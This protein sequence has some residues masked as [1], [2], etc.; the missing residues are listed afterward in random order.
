MAEIRGASF[1][2]DFIELYNPTDAAIDLT[3]WSVEYFASNGSSGGKI[4]LSGTIAP[5]GYYLV[6]GA[7]GNGQAQALP[8]PDAQGKVN[9]S[10]TKGSVQLA[11]ATGNT[12]DLVGYGAASKSEGAA[13]G[14]LSNDTSASRNAAGAD[15]DDNSADFT[16]G[17]PSPT[18]SGNESPAPQP[19]GSD[20]SAGSE[21]LPAPEGITPIAEI[22]GPGDTSPLEGQNVATQGVVTGVWSEGGLNGFTIQTGGTGK[23]ATD[24]SQA[25][26]VHMGKKGADKYP[27]IGDSVEV[28][29][30]V[31]EYYGATQ[32]SASSLKQLDTAL[33]EV[34]PLAVDELLQGDSA[35]ESFEHMLIQPGTHT[36][37]NN[38]SLNQYGEVGLAPGDE[39]FR[40]P[41][42]VHSPSTDPNSDL[43]KLAKDNA[44]KLVTLDDGRTRDYLRTDKDTPLP[45]IAQDGGKTIKSLRTTDTVE[46]QHP[47]I[48]GYSH[49]QWRFQPTEPVTGETAG[50][51]L[52]ISWEESRDAEL[53]AVDDVKGEYTI[54][55][56]NVLNYFTSLGEE[57]G[58]S[59]YTD[60][61]GNKVTVNRGKTRGAYTESALK[62]QE[63]KIVAAINGL[64]ADVI[65]LSEIEDGYAVTGDFNQRDKAL[66][67]LTE[68]LNEAAGSEKWAF[69]PSPSKEQVPEHPDV[70]RTAF[71]YHKDVVKPVGESRIFQDPRFSGTAREPLA[72]EFQPLNSD[73]ESFVAVANHFKSKGSVAKGDEDSGDGQ[74][75]NPNVRNA[76]AQAVLDALH[77]QD[78]WKDK[79]LFALGDFNTYTHETALD[80]FR[81]DGFTVPAEKYGA[82]TSYQFGGLLGTLDHV[83]ANE[84]ASGALDDAQVWNINADEP[85]AFEYSRRNYNAVDFY[86]DSPFRASDHDPVKV[87]FTLGEDEST[88]DGDQG[89]D[90]NQDDNTDGPGFGFGSSSWGTGAIIGFAILAGLLAIPG[91]MAATGNLQKIIPAGI[92]GMLP[93]QAKDFIN[94]LSK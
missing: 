46:F 78:D 3:G 62:D 77:K 66:K 20:N 92:W 56:F 23:E 14:S 76:Q 79:P 35:R 10:G 93:Q 51:D 22:Q 17:A 4:T 41:S 58:G 47:V 63:R 88:D 27:S 6:Q 90:A 26:F 54:G 18:N 89:N 8:T 53:H 13:T 28:T 50:T 69:V 91:F 37:T 30:Q 15:T 49:D 34:T 36:V 44:E 2:N 45:Y 21:N 29:G 75:N 85:V 11:D 81:N 84:V 70:I 83:L 94:G 82:D 19:G 65:G 60:R 71:I 33:E 25:L 1:S 55:A 86:D 31:S 9:M 59:A 72:Q 5:H 12:I 74:G 68:K 57:F 42:D 52:P 24:A 73:D 38:Y 64:D 7:A 43:Q 39:A 32:V 61:E 40:Q 80:V 48:V 67:R 87:G 16:I